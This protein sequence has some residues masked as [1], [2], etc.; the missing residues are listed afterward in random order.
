MK[1]TKN[2]DG[3]YN[4][5]SEDGKMAHLNLTQKKLWDAVINAFKIGRISAARAMYKAMDRENRVMLLEALALAEYD[6][7]LSDGQ[8]ADLF[9][10]LMG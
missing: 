8:L 9:E 4:W 7:G 1:I 10:V 2:T 6:P 3:T 5:E